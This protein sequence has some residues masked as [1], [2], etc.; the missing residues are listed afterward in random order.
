MINNQEFV[1][2]INSVLKPAHDWSGKMENHFLLTRT[3]TKYLIFNISTALFTLNDQK[4]LACLKKFKINYYS[5]S[6]YTN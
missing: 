5:K 4:R 1:C 6:H 2:D 3:Q